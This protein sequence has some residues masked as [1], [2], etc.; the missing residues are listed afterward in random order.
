MRCG[1]L[2]HSR[3]RLPIGTWPTHSRA[4]R[5]FTDPHDNAPRFALSARP[6][7]AR[8]ESGTDRETRARVT[9]AAVRLRPPPLGGGSDSQLG[10]APRIRDSGWA[11]DIIA[12]FD[13]TPKTA[14]K[15]AIAQFEPPGLPSV[16]PFYHARQRSAP[17]SPPPRATDHLPG[18]ALP[19]RDH[20]GEIGLTG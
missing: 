20:G 17:S 1:Q 14:E 18:R 9:S 16:A 6:R 11:W 7:E 13:A 3:E 15:W 19:W 12:H 2:A 10:S 8:G 5:R 4:L